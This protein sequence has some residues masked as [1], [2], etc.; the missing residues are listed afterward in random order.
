[1]I[2]CICERRCQVRIGKRAKFFEVG[3]IWPFPRDKVPK[4]FRIIGEDIPMDEAEKIDFDAISTD[5]IRL[6]DFDA[7]QLREYMVEHYPEVKLHAKLGVEKMISK[8]I[9]ARESSAKV[10]IIDNTGK[11]R[12]AAAELMKEQ[13]EVDSLDD[14]LKD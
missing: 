10:E 5:E 4:R 8:Y 11:D 12:E 3:D 2:D 13:P 9:Y 6:L 7:D 14:L 1:M